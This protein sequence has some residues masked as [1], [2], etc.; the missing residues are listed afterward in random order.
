MD[1]HQEQAERLEADR[2][3]RDRLA[4][5]FKRVAGL[6][7]GRRFLRR[8]LGECGVHQLSFGGEPLAMAFKEGRR[9]VGLWVQGQF[10]ACPDLYIHLLQMVDED[11][12]DGEA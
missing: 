12:G 1:I 2:L 7:A 8:L 6:P 4:A 10:A 9:S 11:G 5:D 3:R